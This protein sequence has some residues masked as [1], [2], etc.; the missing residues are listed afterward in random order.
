[1][2]GHWL[3]LFVMAISLLAC[4][5]RFAA[6]SPAPTVGDT[7]PVRATLTPTLTQTTSLPT[8]TAT[9]YTPTPEPTPSSIS[10]ASQVLTELSIEEA[11][12]YSPDGYCEWKRIL[13]NPLTEAAQLKYANKF[14]IAI[15]LLCGNQDHPWIL[16]FKWAEQGP[17]YLLTSLLGWSA[18]NKYLY[19]YDAVIPD[20]CQPIGGFQQ[21]L[22]R[23]TRQTGEQLSIPISLTGGMAL[24]PD[25][26]RVIYYDWQKMQVGIYDLVNMEEQ[27]IPF[28]LP[29][30][31]QDW[32]AGDFTWSPD[33]QSAVFLIQ[34]GD[35]CFPT[36][37]SLRKVDPQTNTVI[38]V[39]E[40]ENQTVSILSWNAPDKILLSIDKEQQVLDPLTG[41]ISP[42]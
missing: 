13:A 5:P 39:L 8:M 20:G 29:Q 22:R 31:L 24:S 27:R 42:P 41:K 35:A 21:S 30:G 18:D 17:G 4:Q 10:I 12:S 33:G 40:R 36:A 37:Y 3:I 15:T 19:L 32:F 14:L 1:M 6:T 16:D 23:V 9:L 34:Y 26:S 28:S 38:T 11:H 2:K 25:T 7:A